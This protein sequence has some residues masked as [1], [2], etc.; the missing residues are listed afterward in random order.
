VLAD[1]VASVVGLLVAALRQPLALPD[2]VPDRFDAA[3]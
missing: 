1:A 3:S 2:P